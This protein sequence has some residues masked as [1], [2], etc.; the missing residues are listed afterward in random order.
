MKFEH[1]SQGMK[2]VEL[3]VDLY[4]QTKDPENKEMMNKSKS[5]LYTIIESETGIERPTIRRA[6]NEFI[7]GANEGRFKSTA[8][9]KQ[10]VYRTK[11]QQIEYNKTRKEREKANNDKF[12]KDLEERGISRPFGPHS[13]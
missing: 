5:D 6:V 2:I 1:K 9:F 8:D 13:R 7:N 11:E 10:T 12:K 3:Y 4:N